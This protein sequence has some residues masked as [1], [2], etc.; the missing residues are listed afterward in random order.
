MYTEAKVSE[1]PKGE[2]KMEERMSELAQKCMN[3]AISLI[4]NFASSNCF[5]VFC[6]LTKVD[7]NFTTN[8]INTL[9]F[10]I[11][12]KD[13]YVIL[14]IEP[15]HY[16]YEQFCR[17]ITTYKVTLIPFPEVPLVGFNFKNNSIN[18]QENS[19]VRWFEK[20]DFVC[21]DFKPETYRE[22][23]LFKCFQ[24]AQSIQISMERLVDSEQF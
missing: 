7:E 12:N 19:I 21:P 14:K 2:I 9:S 11:S 10:T 4:V 13:S 22:H 8:Q 23:L 3:E 1:Q 24:L 6:G 17:I 16:T 5:K 15:Y 20:L 18:Y